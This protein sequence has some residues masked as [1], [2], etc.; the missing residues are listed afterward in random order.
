[1]KRIN[2]EEA[3]GVPREG[4]CEGVA[5]EN[6]PNG[7]RRPKYFDS[8]GIDFD[9]W[10]AGRGAHICAICEGFTLSGLTSRIS[11]AADRTRAR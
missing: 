3:A 8:T 10:A 5:L 9:E 2:F 6:A 4:T 7:A 1:M 11:R